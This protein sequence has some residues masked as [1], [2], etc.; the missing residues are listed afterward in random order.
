MTIRRNEPRHVYTRGAEVMRHEFSMYFRSLWFSFMLACLTAVGSSVFI[1][2]AFMKANEGEILL[3]RMVAKYNVSAGDKAAPVSM[4]LQIGESTRSFNVPSESLLELTSKE[5]GEIKAKLWWSA[6]LSVVCGIVLF[7]L[8]NYAWRK[9]G[10]SVAVDHVIRGPRF[11]DAEKI[12]K[13]IHDAGEA[14]YVTFAGIPLRK[15][16]EVLNTV[17]AGAIGTGKSVAFKEALAGIRKARARA[18]VF[19]IAGDYIESFYREGRDIILNPFD[20]RSPAWKPWNE[21]RE[22]YDY[23]TMAESFIPVMNQDESFWEEGGQSVFEDVMSR[24]AKQNTTSNR[25][26]VEVINLLSM[27]EVHKIVKNTPAGV[28]L[29]P[30]GGRTAVGMRMNAVKAAKS[31]R[32]MMDDDK[33]G[34]A[35]FS[36]KQWVESED[37]DSWLFVAAREDMLKASRPAMTAWVDTA[38]GAVLTLPASRTRRIWLAIDEL[39]SLKRIPRLQDALTRGRKRGLSAIL[40]YQNYAQV[41]ENYGEN[42]AQT[43]LS[44]CQNRLTLRVPDA[45]TAKHVATDLGAQDLAER[46]ENISFGSDSTRD[47]VTITAKRSNEQQL[48]TYSEIQGLKDLNGYMK[49]AGSN[50]VVKFELK[51]RD[52]PAIAKPFVEKE[53]ITYDLDE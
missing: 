25:K 45:K 28:Y 24:L 21:I 1:A 34:V 18:I 17:I 41:E 33:E 53:Q 40:G 10:E 52:F 8:T 15:K 39:E 14:S 46:D 48:V 30:E 13:D 20:A 26:L 37:E 7:F 19:D 36:I 49:H 43:L 2:N 12:T 29:D 31:L 47:G 5:W 27:D 32:Y 22:S 42:G 3:T 4:S 16:A 35:Q 50:D 6:G 51:L 44:S 11:V 23:G 38:L 9:F